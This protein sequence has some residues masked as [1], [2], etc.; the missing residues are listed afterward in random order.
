M[1]E[2]LWILLLVIA[3]PQAYALTQGEIEGLLLERQ[4]LQQ[5]LAETK[6]ML[7][8]NQDTIDR[9]T[10]NNSELKDEIRLFKQANVD[11][12]KIFAMEKVYSDN[13]VTLREIKIDRI[14]MIKKQ[15][16]IT[17]RINIISDDVR[18]NVEGLQSSGAELVSSENI[19]LQIN[20]EE[21]EKQMTLLNQ[22]EQSIDEEMKSNDELIGQYT[23][24]RDKYQREFEMVKEESKKKWD[25]I[26]GI[27]GAE[28][29]VKSID[30]I[31]T[32]LEEHSKALEDD[33]RQIA[34]EKRTLIQVLEES[35][36]TLIKNQFDKTT[37]KKLVGIKLSKS[38]IT[39][40]KNN[41][42]NN[43]PTY[44]ELS[45]L[46][47]SE[48]K[49]TGKFVTDKNGFFHRAE[50]N[51]QNSWRWYDNDDKVRLI[52]DPPSGMAERIRMV[53]IENNF[54]VYFT[55]GD[56]KIDDEGVRKYHEGRY[57]SKCFTATISAERWG[58]LLA[59]T[60]NMLRTGCEETTQQDLFIEV[61][62]RTDIDITTSPNWQ[63][64]QWLNS[65][66]DLCKT[67]CKQY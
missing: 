16:E 59:D 31:I 43:C 34:Q 29:L 19:N 3:I 27:A 5:E 28:R 30:E 45:V 47:T 44:K 42:S 40:I 53:T 46:D 2:F 62:P 57:I 15:S 56:F 36:N 66:K 17:Q 55:S 10:A 7:K 1:R 13:T 6:E 24:T 38:C 39:L 9:I 33:K 18:Y 23:K 49:V 60:V 52:I 61:L 37:L 25:S 54:G 21:L 8:E 64:T 22:V 67:L 41:F 32:V 12:F 63:Y 50:P 4:A 58:E 26:S 14:E 65:S 11:D 51:F 48:Q 20:I 35:N